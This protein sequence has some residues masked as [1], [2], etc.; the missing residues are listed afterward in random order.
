MLFTAIALQTPIYG[1]RTRAEIARNLETAREAI[2]RVMFTGTME[3]PV[4]IVALPEGALQGFYDEVTD[5]PHLEYCEKVA[6]RIPG[7]ETDA[8]AEKARQY[9]VHLIAQAKALAPEVL[10]D[11]FFN[12]AFVIS[13]AGEVIHRHFKSRVFVHEHSTTP[14]DVW[15]AWIRHFGPGIEALYPVSDTPVGRLGTLVCYEG[16]FPE[17]ARA[18]AVNGAEIV[19]RTAQAEPWTGYGYFE[20]QNRARALDNALFVIAPNLGPYY[21]TI[22]AREAFNIGGGHSM[23]VDYRGRLLAH[24]THAGEGF[25]AAVLN[26]DELREYRRQSMMGLLPHV[27]GAPWAK[28]YEKCGHYPANL[29]LSRPPGNHAETEARYREIVERLLK[30]GTWQ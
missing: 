29:A 1:C 21:H 20:L 16:R 2:D 11:R 28:I 9:K 27:L 18:L 6:I 25:A 19:Y 23:I 24:V 26:L 3:A 30:E 4:A 10:P 13:P 8:L 15:D 5:M 12:V 22:D 14:Y 17:T 7:P